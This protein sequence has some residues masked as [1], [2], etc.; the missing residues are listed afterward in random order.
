[1]RCGESHSTK[2]MNVHLCTEIFIQAPF[3]ARS[4]A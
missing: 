4:G 2:D 3:E 1:L